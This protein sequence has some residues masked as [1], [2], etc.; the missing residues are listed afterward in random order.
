MIDIN[1]I[2]KEQFDSASNKHLPS[3][4][5][6]FA[7]KYFSSKT[8]NTNLSVKR[9]IIGLLFGLFAVGFLGTVFNVSR[10]LI[11]IPT[12]IYTILLFTLV[13]YISSA[14]ILN[15]LRLIK[16]INELGITKEEYNQLINKYYPE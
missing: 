10:I 13:I 14:V 9:S 12:L 6:K 5:I 7:F 8:E 4:W 16:I 15:N 3:E 1:T 2:T 11:M